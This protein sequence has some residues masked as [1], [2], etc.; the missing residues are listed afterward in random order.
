M[1]GAGRRFMTALVEPASKRRQY[2]VEARVAL[3]QPGKEK[4]PMSA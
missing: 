1:K 3:D 4:A 2:D